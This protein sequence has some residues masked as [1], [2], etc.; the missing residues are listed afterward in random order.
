MAMIE[1]CNSGQ[2]K[3]VETQ[4]R[5]LVN[6]LENMKVELGEFLRDPGQPTPNAPDCPRPLM[7]PMDDIMK[8]LD[9][10]LGIAGDIR[11]MIFDQITHRLRS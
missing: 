1:S 9:E 4:A 3:T 10:A 8:A 5:E 7:N 11:G 6:F 2:Q